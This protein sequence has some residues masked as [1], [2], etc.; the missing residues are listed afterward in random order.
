MSNVFCYTIQEGETLGA[1]G[2]W[3]P[4]DKTAEKA[5]AASRNA[6]TPVP[7]ATA[8]SLSGEM[9]TAADLPEVVEQPVFVPDNDSVFPDPLVQVRSIYIIMLMH[10]VCEMV[11]FLHV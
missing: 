4:V 1:Y 9:V 2:E 11:F 8:T 5:S 10:C 3:V 7:I 6:L